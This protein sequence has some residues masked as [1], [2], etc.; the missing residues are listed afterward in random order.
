MGRLVRA[1]RKSV[2]TQTTTIYNHS[3]QK[4]ISKMPD[5]TITIADNTGF[6]SFQPRKEKSEAIV[7]NLKSEAI[8]DKVLLKLD[9]W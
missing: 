4:S 9:S 7:D 6:H 2:G 1:A 3:K 8:V 5:W